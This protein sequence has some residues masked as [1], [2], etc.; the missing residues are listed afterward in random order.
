MI[1]SLIG[2]II[3][4]RDGYITSTLTIKYC[5]SVARLIF[6]FI[7]LKTQ[8]RNLSEFTI[9]IVKLLRWGAVIF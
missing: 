8:Y 3:S 4:Y 5:C 7:R 1:I 6:V 9:I 2:F